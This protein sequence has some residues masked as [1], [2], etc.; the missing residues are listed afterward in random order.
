MLT[1]TFWRDALERAVKTFCQSLVAV[2]GA[3]SVGLL[4]VP[5]VTSLSTAGLA[6]LLSLLTSVGS[7]PLG[8]RGDP[9]LLPAE[10]Q[11]TPE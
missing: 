6:A 11:P 10:R 1:L 8:K 5:W 7:S 2:L 9:S 3:G 4:N